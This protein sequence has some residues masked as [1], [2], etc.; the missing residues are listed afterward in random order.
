MAGDIEPGLLSLREE[1]LLRP[2]PQIRDLPLYLSRRTLKFM[3]SII[4]RI[5]V[6]NFPG[7]CCG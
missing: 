7:S 6:L 3:K 4:A 2:R 5:D 1:K